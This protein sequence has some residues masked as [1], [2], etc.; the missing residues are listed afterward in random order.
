MGWAMSSNATGKW[1]W[2]HIV[3]WE[4]W[5][6]AALVGWCAMVPGDECGNMLS[7]ELGHLQTMG[8]FVDLMPKIADEYPLAGVN[9]PWHPWG[10]ILQ[11]VGFVL[12]IKHL[13][14]LRANMIQ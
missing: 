13:I 3:Y 9:M 7:H 4:Y 1:T 5:S 11:A 8:H 2:N 12:G 6:A 10:M 14:H